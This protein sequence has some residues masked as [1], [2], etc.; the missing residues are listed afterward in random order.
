MLLSKLPKGEAKKMTY[1]RVYSNV[2]N[3][4]KKGKRA[5]VSL[6]CKRK[7]PLIGRYYPV[8]NRDK[9]DGWQ[10]QKEK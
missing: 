7:N 2:N 8:I 6:I 4:P 5:A 9:E 3:N 1:N 10:T